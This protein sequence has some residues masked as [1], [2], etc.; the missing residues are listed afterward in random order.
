MSTSHMLFRL[1]APL[2][3]DPSKRPGIV[4][5]DRIPF[6]TAEEIRGRLLATPGFEEGWGCIQ[7]TSGTRSFE[8]YLIEDPVKC[9]S[10]ARSSAWDVLPVVDALYDLGPFA[11]YSDQEAAHDPDELRNRGLEPPAACPRGGRAP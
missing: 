11:I 5:L 7:L 3:K 8:L 2:P 10:V 6:G 1:K 4:E 9:I